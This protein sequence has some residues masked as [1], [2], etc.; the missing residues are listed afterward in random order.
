MKDSLGEIFKQKAEGYGKMIGYTHLALDCLKEGEKDIIKAKNLINIQDYIDFKNE[1][2][3]MLKEM[4]LKNQNIYFD[5][6]P[7]LKLLPKV[8]KLIKALPLNPPDDFNKFIEG[9]NSLD[10]MIPKEVKLM[11]DNYKQSV[12]FN[13]IKIMS[14]IQTSLDKYENEISLTQFLNSL[15]LPTSLEATMTMSIR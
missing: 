7:E 8:E 3:N 4:E 10:D 11:V 14:F 12:S 5:F 1:I 2:E 13:I 15:N 6:I 9:Q